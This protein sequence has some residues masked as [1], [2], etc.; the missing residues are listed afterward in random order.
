ML[1]ENV[2]SLLK[3][4]MWYLGTFND[5]EPNT[6]PVAF[7]NV[8]EDGKLLVGD[9]F[10]DKTLA[11]IKINGR[12]AVSVCDPTTLEGYQIKGTADYYT[13]GFYVESFAKMV[14]NVFDG[15]RTAKGALV[16]TPEKVYVTTPGDDNNK[17]L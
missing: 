16:I 17:R 10:L 6:V 13:E 11:N 4:N 1:N 3:D 9:V 12:I 2:V 15:E 8:T 7:T 5:K 14:E